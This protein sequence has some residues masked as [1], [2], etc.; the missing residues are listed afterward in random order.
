M[1]FSNHILSHWFSILKDKGPP[2]IFIKDTNFMIVMN[3]EAMLQNLTWILL[4]CTRRNRG[5]SDK[6]TI[7]II[8]IEIFSLAWFIAGN[9]FKMLHFNI[10]GSLTLTVLFIQFK[11]SIWVY[12]INSYVDTSDANSINYCHKVCYTFAFWIITVIYGL[13]FALGTFFL[14]FKA[15]NYIYLKHPFF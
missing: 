12:S 6:W 8:I 11:G 15:A 5:L 7:W 10:F 13:A 1:S 14:L 9:I 2:N 3:T 4:I